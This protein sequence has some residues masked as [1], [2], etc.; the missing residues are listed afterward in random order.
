ML[1]DPWELGR[2]VSSWCSA[3]LMGSAIR[4]GVSWGVGLE[5]A[6]HSTPRKAGTS[7]HVPGREELRNAFLHPSCRLLLLNCFPEKA[8]KAQPQPAQG[9]F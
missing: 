3:R 9:Y 5:A 1:Q 6:P 7:Q 2:E 8:E 4:I